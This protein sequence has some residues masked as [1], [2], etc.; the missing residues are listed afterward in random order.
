VEGATLS[1]EINK[2]YFNAFCFLS[3]F[4][5]IDCNLPQ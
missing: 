1:L 2:D 4:V 3:P 5:T